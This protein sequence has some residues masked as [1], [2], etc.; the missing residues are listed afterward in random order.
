[1]WS[2]LYSVELSDL[3]ECVNTR[4][5]ATVEAENLILDHSCQGQVIKEFCEL[6]P[7]VCVAVLSQAL[8]IK[9]IHLCDLSALVVAS[10]NSESVLE[11]D[12]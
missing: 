4:R 8:I 12:L 3:I 10:E 11:A 7:D 1:M 9:S 5:E 6:F 2:F